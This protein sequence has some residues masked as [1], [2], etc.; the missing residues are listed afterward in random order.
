[1]G[2][3]PGP[4]LKGVTFWHVVVKLLTARPVNHDETGTLAVSNQRPLPQGGFAL[5]D[6]R[7]PFTRFHL[8]YAE[9]LV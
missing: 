4:A 6:S 9:A 1:M 8:I 7:G 5:Q 2:N 3:S